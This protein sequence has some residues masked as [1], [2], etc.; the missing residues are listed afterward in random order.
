[1]VL[2]AVTAL[3]LLFFPILT[4]GY[5]Y[6]YTIPAFGPL[7]AAGALAAWGLVVRVTARVRAA[8]AG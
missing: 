3:V 7:L 6:R 4:T 2:F 8:R 1:M 5:D